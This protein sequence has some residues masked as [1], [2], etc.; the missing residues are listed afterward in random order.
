MLRILGLTVAAGALSAS[1]ATADSNAVYTLSVQ[2]VPDG[3]ASQAAVT[4][5][6]FL[7]L[8]YGQDGLQGDNN[9]LSFFTFPQPSPQSVIVGFTE[10]ED[11]AALA[12]AQGSVMSNPAAGAY[13][14]T[15]EMQALLALM[16]EDGEHFDL[17]QYLT[18]P[19]TVVE[20]AV[21]RPREGME[22]TFLE[23]REAFFNSVSEQPGHL[24]S[25]EFVMPE[26]A[27]ELIGKGSGWTAVLIG[28]D[29]AAAY[30]ATLGTLSQQPEMGAFQGTIETLLYHATVPQ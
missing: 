1:M 8:I 13:M 11:G 22:D 6:G 17:E 27:T 4:R 10:W 24:F 23:T 15:V 7:D 2:T 18:D 16:T 19:N 14:Q 30:Q 5:A 3:A 29:S 28:W 20:F 9:F 21:R 25:R 12:N 26:G